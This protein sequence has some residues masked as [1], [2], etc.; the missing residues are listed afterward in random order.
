MVRTVDDPSLDEHERRVVQDIATYGMHVTRVLPNR[1]T[2]GWAFSVGLW[3]TYQHPE[4]LVFGLD[5]GVAHHMLNHIADDIKVGRPF[6]V[7]HEY[8]DL[9]EGVR[10]M[11]KPVSPIWHYP[12]LGWADWFYQ[13]V[14]YPVLQ[15]IW[16]DHDQHYPW[17]RGFREEWRW[18]QPLLFHT[19]VEAAR[20][21]PLLESM[22]LQHKPGA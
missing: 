10:C 17:E 21:A 22:G 6:Q 5:A 15:C 12:F 20:A 14:E 4:V 1:D 2:P 3:H 9:L 8:A 16:P 19:N 7:E 13:H 11:F 18:V